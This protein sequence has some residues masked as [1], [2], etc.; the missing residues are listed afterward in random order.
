MSRGK[1]IS[2]PLFQLKAARRLSAVCRLGIRG[3]LAA[4]I[5]WPIYW[6]MAGRIFIVDVADIL[7][8]I[9]TW[10]LRD[11]VNRWLCVFVYCPTWFIMKLPRFMANI[12][13]YF[14]LYCG[15]C[16]S[17]HPL[18]MFLLFVAPYTKC[19]V[20]YWWVIANVAEL[21]NEE[22]EKIA[23]GVMWDRDL[24]WL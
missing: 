1:Q 14:V 24:L 19:I 16:V 23:N 18:F 7:P 4:L 2:H 17:K 11:D 20:I 15:S 21:L 5:R 9:A 13:S 12:F 22:A 3:D 10:L 8:H 6:M